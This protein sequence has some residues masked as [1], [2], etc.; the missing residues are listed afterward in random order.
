MDIK[1]ENILFERVLAIDEEEIKLEQQH[2]TQKADRKN[3]KDTR[4]KLERDSSKL[5]KNQKRRLK[6]KIKKLEKK[7]DNH[8]KLEKLPS[9]TDASEQFIENFQKTIDTEN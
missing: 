2:F 5:S 9:L 4:R 7:I 1:P 8:P 3:L 6:E